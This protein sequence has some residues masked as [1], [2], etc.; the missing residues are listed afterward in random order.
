VNPRRVT[1]VLAS[2]AR[3]GAEIQGLGL[4]AQLAARG[5]DTQTVALTTGGENGLDVPVLSEPWRS[6]AGWRRLRSVLEGSVVVAHGSVTLPA[7]AM[8]A[9][10]TGSP[11]CYRS[12]GD[13]AAWVKGP[14]HR[15]RTG[16]LMRRADLVVAL[17][18][19]AARAVHDLYRVPERR[20]RVIT[21]D[22]S[23]E[24]WPLVTPPERAA[25]RE[26]VGVPDS[27]PFVVAFVGALSEEKRPLDAIRA[28]AEQ[29]G[30]RLLVAGAGPLEGPARSLAESGAPDRVH[31][32]GELADPREVYAAADALLVPSRTEGMPGVIIEALLSGLAVVASAVGAAP[33][34]I[35][36]GEDGLLVVPGDLPGLGAA[37][38]TVAADPARWRG[39]GR[40]RAVERYAPDRVTDQ[41]VEVL[42]QLDPSVGSSQ[43]RSS[44][45]RRRPRSR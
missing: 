30:A 22:R 19:G 43:S 7:V 3:R 40:E 25:A 17:W 20:L 34:M 33:D 6:V 41:W 38:R 36:D 21:N 23:P 32:L 31:F 18:S 35:S 26:A 28:V 1:V 14:L 2:A 45:S 16:M 44:R 27:T 4:A 29:P 12:I 11:W 39:R 37:L 8:A 24:R 13:P 42:A 9:A 10:A 15:E 5:V